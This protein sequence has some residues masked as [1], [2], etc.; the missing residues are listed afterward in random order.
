VGLDLSFLGHL[1]LMNPWK[2]VA[3]AGLTLSGFIMF[4]IYL[5]SIQS[6]L[7]WGARGIIPH[8]VLL[9]LGLLVVGIMFDMGLIREESRR[10]FLIYGRMYIQPQNPDMLPTNE[11]APPTRDIQTVP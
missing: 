3:L 10:P 2:Y 5:G 9:I 11:Y 4:V 1:G 7:K 8:V 6:G